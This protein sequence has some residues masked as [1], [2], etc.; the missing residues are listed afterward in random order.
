MGASLGINRNLYTG[1]AFVLGPDEALIVEVRPP[2]R[3]RY[4]GIQLGSFWMEPEGAMLIRWVECDSAPRPTTKRVAFDEVRGAL[5]ASTS[6]VTP[7][8]RAAIVERRR[9]HVARRYR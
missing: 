6:R 7:Q 3:C 4:W 8:Q 5:P 9:S 1:G 2:P